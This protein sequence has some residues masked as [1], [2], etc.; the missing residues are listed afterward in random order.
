[1]GEGFSDHKSL[2]SAHHQS[3]SMA[4]IAA[5][6]K[7]SEDCD[8][9][10]D[11]NKWIPYPPPSQGVP[12]SS[13]P[14]TF[15]NKE[16]DYSVNTAA[17]NGK[18]VVGLANQDSS[19]AVRNSS[20]SNISSGVNGGEDVAEEIRRLS[21]QMIAKLKRLVSAVRSSSSAQKT[22]T[23]SS[24]RHLY[25][26]WAKQVADDLRSFSVRLDLDLECSWKT[27]PFQE[28]VVRRR[29]QRGNSNDNQ[30][31]RGVGGGGGKAYHS[32]LPSLRSLHHS[33]NSLHKHTTTTTTTVDHNDTPTNVPEPAAAASTTTGWGEKNH[34]HNNHQK[35]YLHFSHLNTPHYSSSASSTL[36]GSISH[37][38]PPP[39]LP[40]LPH[41]NSKPYYNFHP[42]RNY[43]DEVPYYEQEQQQQR[44]PHLT[45]HLLRGD[46]TA[47]PH[48]HLP[49]HHQQ[50]GKRPRYKEEKEGKKSYFTSAAPTTATS[51]QGRSTVNSGS[52]EA[53]NNKQHLMDTGVETRVTTKFTSAAD[54][55]RRTLEEE[56]AASLAPPAAAAAA[57]P[58]LPSQLTSSQLTTTSSTLAMGAPPPHLP[59]PS[60]Q[61]NQR[62]D[63]LPPLLHDLEHIESMGN[64]GAVDDTI[65]AEC[66]TAP[67]AAADAQ[68]S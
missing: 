20:S 54:Y 66:P 18:Y 21:E 16:H 49:H 22:A 19:S 55:R 57:A 24:Q 40:T 25:H 26:R 41:Y 38:R 61:L 60:A 15:N 67:S 4:A 11:C 28:H 44:P 13:S 42:S 1:V 31:R 63:H 45:Q 10:T 29:H 35:D 2:Q 30:Q 17:S 32:T 47:A 36:P 8:R 56:A 43:A 52:F 37:H 64:E 9:Y 14:S 58:Y 34:Q 59:H 3:R 65:S 6:S 48:M 7:I 51:W 39:P 50:Q 5:L 27:N 46:T 23:T 12:P 62:L 33:K 68:I 53:K